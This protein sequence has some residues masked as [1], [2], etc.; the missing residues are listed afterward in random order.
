M[1]VVLLEYQ[2]PAKCPFSVRISCKF[3]AIKIDS[4]KDSVLSNTKKRDI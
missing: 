2:P 4:L 1:R 3:N